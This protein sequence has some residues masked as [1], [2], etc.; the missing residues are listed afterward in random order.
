[1]AAAWT[2]AERERRCVEIIAADIGRIPMTLTTRG[3]GWPF[4]V[5]EDSNGR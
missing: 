4:M 5:Q 1:M 3:T 2:E